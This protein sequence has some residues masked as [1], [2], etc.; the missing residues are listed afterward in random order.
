DGLPDA[1][2]DAFQF[3]LDPLAQPLE[4]VLHL[5]QGPSRSSAFPRPF[6]AGPS[7]SGTRIGSGI[8]AGVRARSGLGPL[9]GPQQ[10]VGLVGL[11][12]PLPEQ[13]QNHLPFLGKIHAPSPFRNGPL[14]QAPARRRAPFT[15]ATPR[16]PASAPPLLQQ[17]PTKPPAALIASAGGFA[18]IHK[19]ARPR[20]GEC[21]ARPGAL[22][23]TLRRCAAPTRTAGG[24]PSCVAARCRG[25]RP[26]PSGTCGHPAACGD[27]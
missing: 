7:C 9:Q 10:L 17:T 5:V 24:A 23:E 1:L 8:S 14:Q 20:P 15:P 12:A 2:L 3:F 4:P 6:V 19:P 11:D 18:T 21:R 25:C 26:E 16:R 13:A 22:P 27:R